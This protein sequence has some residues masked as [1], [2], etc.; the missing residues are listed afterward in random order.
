M[1]IKKEAKNIITKARAPKRLGSELKKTKPKRTHNNAR[2][3]FIV[4]NC[5]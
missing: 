4:T 5:Y 2:F 1:N 3:A